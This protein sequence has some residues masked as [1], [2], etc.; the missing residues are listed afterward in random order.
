MEVV[1]PGSRSRPEAEMSENTCDV[2]VLYIPEDGTCAM[3]TGQSANT[4]LT[5]E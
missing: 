5:K 3:V 4:I 1:I 2:Q